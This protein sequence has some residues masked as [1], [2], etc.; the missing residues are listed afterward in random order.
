MFLR[1]IL[2]F[3]LLISIIIFPFWL[4][5]IFAIFLTLYFDQYYEVIVAGFLLDFTYSIPIESFFGFR[6]IYALI[7]TIIFLISGPL[8]LR[9]RRYHK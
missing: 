3:A 8:K 1:L 5:I 6:F 9:L 4:N 7:F 2:S